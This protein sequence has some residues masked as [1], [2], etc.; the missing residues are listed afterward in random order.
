MESPRK[1]LISG[2]GLVG[3]L[4]AIAM[5]KRGHHVELYELRTDMRRETSLA[6]KS[7]NLIIT[8]KGINP[9][10]NLGLWE[11]VKTIIT[12][13]T[14]R[15]MHSKSVELTY[16]PYGKDET[17]CNYSVSRAELNKMLMTEAEEIGVIIHFEAG[18]KSLDTVN[19]TAYFNN[20]A[21]KSY[22]LF[23]GAD[24][25][26]SLTRKA[27]IN[28]LEDQ[29]DY[30]TE[31]LGSHYKE[32]LMPADEKGNYQ[33]DK[34][35]LHIWPR[36][37]HMLMALPNQD[38][39]FTMTL[40]MPEQW[41]K[42]FNTEEKVKYYFE[43]NY[44]D[45]IKLMPNYL[46]EYAD[47]PQG[48][49][50]CVRMSPWIYQDQ[51]ILLGDAAHAIVPF[52]GQGMN[53]GFSDVQFLIDQLDKNNDNLSK[54]FQAYD[55]HQKP[56]GDAI[57]DLSIENFIEMCE[58]VGD[59]NFLFRKKV[60]HIVEKAYPNLYR[61]RYGMVTYTLI[62]YHKAKEA[63]EIQAKIITELC[64]GLKNAEDVNLQQARIL[65]ESKLSPWLAENNLSIERFKGI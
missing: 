13:V 61:S 7:I 64:Q 37:N 47:N 49:L 9:V 26:G 19:K 35:A 33:M 6:G 42:D 40:Y 48:F 50:G 4:M 1:V 56:N 63:G 51:I 21:K 34:K 28:S 30:K 15:M 54:A 59:E 10:I 23:F 14:G 32:L 16:Q 5:K 55:A 11:S 3:S 8:A 57:A 27:M 60:E 31:P 25:A 18:L 12:P 43:E 44:P 22:D 29:A 52:F 41:Y 39:S 36:G 17:E 58:K 20:G 24:G 46:E 62:P 2:A 45:A 53:C 38:G 65:I